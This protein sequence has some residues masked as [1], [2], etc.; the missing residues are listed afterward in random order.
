[1]TRGRAKTLTDERGF[2]SLKQRLLANLKKQE[3]TRPGDR[4][5]VAV[6]GGADSVALL[7]LLLELREKLGIVLS[8]VHFNHKLRGKASDADEAFVAKLAV[9]HGL[10]FH[11]ASVYVAKKAKKERANLEDAARRA[12]Y[13]YFRSLAESGV[14]GRVA[15]AHTA[16]DQ[17]ETVLAH[18]LRGTGLTGLGGI[19]PAAGPVIRPLLSVRRSELRGFLRAR[20]QSWREDATN[21]D[22]KRMRARIRKKLLPLLEKQFQPGIVEHLTTLAT[23]AREDEAFFETAVK[24]RLASLVQK[25]GGGAAIGI[26]GLL[27]PGK[28]KQLNAEGAENT[29]TAEK[30]HAGRALSKRMVRRIV[31]SIK[32]RGG[33]LGAGH[34]EAVLQLARSGQS[35]SSLTL[36]GGVEVRKEQDAVVFQVVENTGVRTSRSTPR[37]YEY[38][39]DLARGDAEVNVAELG[40]VFRLRVIDWP[41]KRGETSKDGAV[42]DRDRLRFP[43]VLRNWRPGDRLRPL[44]HRSAH[45]L[46]RLLNEKR[47]SRWERDGWPVLASGGVLVWA[48]GFPVAAEF[49]ANERTRSGIVILE[50]KI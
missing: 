9:K 46:K 4:V 13:D 24:E 23:L 28:R 2:T 7:L 40:C 19:H 26:I 43:I 12:R 50:E 42:L 33:Q 29:E 37:E 41:P 47:V 6:S 49:G 10:E 44:G 18:I 34:V 39:I 35:G 15:V 8:V 11:S 27:E 30:N 14:C 32:P 17:A 5:G 38:K 1:V 16:D 22:T 31:E 36:P 25:S 3:M 45:K 48:R 21:R 20:K